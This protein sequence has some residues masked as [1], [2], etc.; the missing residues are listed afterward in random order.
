MISLLEQ[1]GEQ[2]ETELRFGWIWG[3]TISDHNDKIVKR[4][5]WADG[6]ITITIWELP[7]ANRN[8]SRR[9][10]THIDTIN[11]DNSDKYFA[12]LPTLENWNGVK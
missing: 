12:W 2:D 6:S 1:Y 9:P 3:T 7:K 11:F 8:K 10:Y 4:V 5:A